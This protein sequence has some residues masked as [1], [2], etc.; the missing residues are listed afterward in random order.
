[1][2]D[3]YLFLYFEKNDKPLTLREL[4]DGVMK[5]FGW[6][7]HR[8]SLESVEGSVENF[9]RWFIM[10]GYEISFVG[11]RDKIFE[12]FICNEIY[13][14]YKIDIVLFDYGL[15]TLVND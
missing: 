6:I 11:K 7:D 8:V 13:D 14:I 10:N 1:M 4:Q 2:P 3:Y 9:S 12:Y 15:P 5:D